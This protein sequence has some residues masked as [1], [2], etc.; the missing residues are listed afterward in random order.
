VTKEEAIEQY[1]Q[2]QLRKAGL[3]SDGLAAPEMAAP[4]GW[5]TVDVGPG[6]A[7]RYAMNQVEFGDR[8]PLSALA[9]GGAGFG[10]GLTVGGPDQPLN[11]RLQTAVAGGVVG[12]AAGAAVAKR[13][14]VAAGRFI[15][16]LIGRGFL[17][18]EIL[19]TH[20]HI[21]DRAAAMLALAARDL[22]DDAPIVRP[23]AMDYLIKAHNYQELDFPDALADLAVRRSP[24]EPITAGEV[25]AAVS[26]PSMLERMGKA[27][28]EYLTDVVTGNSGRATR[29]KEFQADA[30]T[31]RKWNSIPRIK[32]PEGTLGSEYDAGDL[33]RAFR[34]APANPDSSPEALRLH[35]ILQETADELGIPAPEMYFASSDHP[36]MAIQRRLDGT[37]TGMLVTRGVLKRLDDFTDD[38]LRGVVTHELAHTVQPQILGLGMLGRARTI[39][40][41][42]DLSNPPAANA[43]VGAGLGAMAEDE[44]D[45]GYSWEAIAGGGL[46]GGILKKKLNPNLVKKFAAI[47]D[48]LT[49]S[50]R[51]PNQGVSLKGQKFSERAY[52]FWQNANVKLFDDLGRLQG[53]QNDLAREFL[54]QTGMRLPA[55]MLFAE[56]KRFDFS[57]R[58]KIDVTE[59]ITHGAVKTLNDAGVPQENFDRYLMARQNVDILRAQQGDPKPPGP[60][61]K[62]PYVGDLTRQFPGNSNYEEEVKL[63]Q[64]YETIF[65]EEGTWDAVQSAAEDIWSL[66]GRMLDLLEGGGLIDKTL[67]DTLRTKYP[68]Y[69]PTRILEKLGD[70]SFTPP[71]KS[72]SINSN[73][74]RELTHEGTSKDALNPTAAMTA[75]IYQVHAAVQKNKVANAFVDAW[76]TASGRVNT[77]DDSGIGQYAPDLT[78][79]V[80]R[81]IQRHVDGIQPWPVN[82][83]VPTGWSPLTN[84]RNGVKEKFIVSD[85]LAPL[86]NFAK[87]EHIKVISEAMNFF[88]QAVTTRNPV[89]LASNMFLDLSSFLIRESSRAGG[90]QHMPEVFKEWFKSMTEFV[91]SPAA[92]ADIAEQRYSG[93]MARALMQGGGMSGGYYPGGVQ[94]AK[95]LGVI[96]WIDGKPEDI[97]AVLKKY[98]IRDPRSPIVKEVENM[99]RGMIEINTAGGV[100]RM[101]KDMLTFKPVEAIGERIEAA[102]RVAAMRLSEKRVDKTLQLLNQERAETAQAIA[103]LPAGSGSGIGQKLKDLGLRSLD[104]IDAEIKDTEA[105]RVIEGTQAYRTTTIDFNKGGEFSRF[106]NQIVPFFNVG[107]QSIADVPRAFAENKVGYPATVIAGVTVPVM[108]A[109]QWNNMDPQR[110]KD[111]ADIPTHIKDQG[112]VVM[113][114]GEAPVDEKG[115]RVPQYYHFRYRQLAPIAA[116]TR[117]MLQRTWFREQLPAE[118]EQRSLPEMLGSAASMVSPVPVDDP[119]EFAV[120]L[121]PPI[122]GTGIQATMDR[123]LFRGKRIT[124]EFADDRASPL[125]KAAWEAMDK[126]KG[127]RPSMIEFISRDAAGGY[128][129][130]WH[131]VANMLDG[132]KTPG[133]AGV[134]VVGPFAGRFIKGGGGGKSQIAREH[135]LTPSAEELLKKHNVSWSPSP[136]D[137]KIGDVPLTLSEYGDYQRAV[138]IAVD[139]AIQETARKADFLV[140]SPGEKTEMIER[141][142]GFAKDAV[143]IKFLS[144]IPTAERAKRRKLEDDKEKKGWTGVW[145]SPTSSTPSSSGTTTTA[146]RSAPSRSGP[147]LPATRP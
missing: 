46:A 15:D 135:L 53:Y 116:L 94:P 40:P 64:K 102:P 105:R 125:S 107:M 128:A 139:K 87:P 26:D 124:S 12:T 101:M 85:E 118:N 19:R 60:D 99:R 104:S 76:D 14:S 84:F 108:L 72:M 142:V 34:V 121:V 20:P 134:P 4:Q 11:E 122:V 21:S 28:S 13:G 57:N 119:A 41:E 23:A 83:A 49:R 77:F 10:T 82:D 32:M 123:D 75:A 126:P 35:Q 66:S 144:Q 100:A 55:E 24:D 22:P 43:A 143:R 8:V 141:S 103:G 89:F 48:D 59:Y 9:S 81:R 2:T 70:N 37:A 71:S 95:K 88:R 31:V 68:H 25:R 39:F 29:A 90:P 96:D 73:Q 5:G 54:K 74:I 58:A 86:V 63:L 61:S 30:M 17:N 127:M 78:T 113:L 129:N 38:E 79:D 146:P 133:V 18:E 117:E 67:A 98:N 47:E 111:Y 1:A 147:I 97:D 114:P 56:M 44:D 91:A 36:N 50:F 52:D 132:R 136:V 27:L 42:R 62:K 145:S 92:W 115:N 93:D 112:L 106:V 16:R 69:I 45:G 33:G 7:E 120:G 65:K 6:R 138:N 80:G 51:S 130:F 137:Y 109:E 140:K 110:A 131:G 3:I